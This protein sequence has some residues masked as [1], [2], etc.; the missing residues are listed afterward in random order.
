MSS[1][2]TIPGVRTAT[3]IRRSLH[4][5]TVIRPCFPPSATPLSP[6]HPSLLYTETGG[7]QGSVSPTPLAS[8]TSRPYMQHAQIKQA[9]SSSFHSVQLRPHRRLHIWLLPQSTKPL[10]HAR[11][12]A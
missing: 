8:T 10:C 9:P 11:A 5:P 12:S 3:H 6:A 7:N 1:F 4:H 2:S